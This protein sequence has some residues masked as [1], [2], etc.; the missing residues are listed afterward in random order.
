MPSLGVSRSTWP[1]VAWIRL[2]LPPPE[3][4]ILLTPGPPPPPDPPLEALERNP[5]PTDPKKRVYALE[6]EIGEHLYRLIWDADDPELLEAECRT[7]R[8]GTRATPSEVREFWAWVKRTIGPL[9]P[10]PVDGADPRP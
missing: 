5:V 1:V 7:P 3:A 4:P 8:F 6:E 10:L 9:G 2:R